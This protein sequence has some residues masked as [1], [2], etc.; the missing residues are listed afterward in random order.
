MDFK[1]SLLQY[2]AQYWI[3][4]AQQ[5][6]VLFFLSIFLLPGAVLGSS[7]MILLHNYYSESLALFTTYYT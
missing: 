1:S 2:L 7:R 3:V 6:V 5:I 4:K